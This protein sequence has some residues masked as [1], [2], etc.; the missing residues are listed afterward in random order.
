[1]LQLTEHNTK[2][3]HKNKL[4]KQCLMRLVLQGTLQNYD[5]VEACDGLLQAAAVWA[6]AQWPTV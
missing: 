5:G 4:T 2:T 1:M 3:K 6:S